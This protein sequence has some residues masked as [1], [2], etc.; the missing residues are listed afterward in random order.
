V[1]RRP[2]QPVH[3]ETAFDGS[4]RALTWQ[5]VTYDVR[6]ISQ[7]YLKDR[8]YTPTEHGNR[9]YYRVQTDDYRVQA[10][11]RHI[12]ELY[13]DVAQNPPLWILDAIE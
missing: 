6:V 10:D 11:D 1:E 5:G 8:W 2:H 9:Y 4:P 12:F 7:W 3:V 13:V